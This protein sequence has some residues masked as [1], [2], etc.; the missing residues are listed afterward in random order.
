MTTIPTV[1]VPTQ[2]TSHALD[3]GTV[4]FLS[5]Q[6][7]HRNPIGSHVVRRHCSMLR[8]SG[9]TRRQACAPGHEVAAVVRLET[10]LYQVE[11]QR[12]ASGS[13]SN[14]LNYPLCRPNPISPWPSEM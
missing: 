7:W 2:H 1:C 8:L 10:F 4:S 6:K 12:P 11:H 9:R 5:S 3:L 14:P 13:F